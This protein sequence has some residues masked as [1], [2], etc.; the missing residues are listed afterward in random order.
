MDMRGR[1]RSSPLISRVEKMEK[2]HLTNIDQRIATTSRSIWE[3]EDFV[4]DGEQEPRAQRGPLSQPRCEPW[5][6]I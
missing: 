2:D 4:E 5:F 1:E 6:Q 3:S